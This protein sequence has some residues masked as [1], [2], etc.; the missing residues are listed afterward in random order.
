MKK[1]YYLFFLS[2]IFLFTFSCKKPITPAYLVLLTPETVLDSIYVDVSNFNKDHNTNYDQDELA[3]LK[4]HI[5][6]DVYISI[7]G[8]AMYWP[9]PCTIPVLPDYS[10]ENI[11]RIIPC[12]RMISTSLTTVQY[13]FFKPIEQHI[14][15]EKEEKYQISSIKLEYRDEVTFPVLETFVQSTDFAS[16]DTI[17]GVDLELSYDLE[18]GHVGKIAFTDS[19]QYFNIATPYFYL[20]GKGVRHFWQ[21][22]YKSYDGEMTTYLNFKNTT[23]GATV[24]NLIEISDTKG[25]WKKFYFDITDIISQTS[26][27]ASRVSVRLG[28]RG[29]QN[30]ETP[31][32]VPKNAQF[33]FK[34]VSIIS[35]EA[36]Y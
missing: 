9:L 15:F 2:F 23:T 35:M 19:K 8:H 33:Y 12:V 26:G 5:I 16:I 24:M 22:Y 1:N 28:I 11:V 18:K 17:H 31:N 27:T 29:L 25:E 30:E 10:R 32:Y 13:H 4:Q 14:T 34:N 21:M 7:N 3:V 6:K 36:R 20:N